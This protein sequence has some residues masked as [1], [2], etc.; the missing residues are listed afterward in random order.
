MKKFTKET[1]FNYLVGNDILDFNIDELENNPEFMAEVVCKDKNS[2]NLCSDEIKTNIVFIR[3]ILDNYKDDMDFAL[4]VYKEFESIIED[5]ENVNSEETQQD[6]FEINTIMF[7]ITR[8]AQDREVHIPFKIATDVFVGIEE[9]EFEILESQLKKKVPGLGF[10]YESRKYENSENIVDF[11]AENFIR[12]IFSYDVNLEELLHKHYKSYKEY[13]ENG[14]YTILIKYISYYDNDLAN[15]VSL[16]PKALENFEDELEDIKKNWQRYEDEQKRIEMAKKRYKD[17]RY[18]RIIER[19]KDYENYE[20]CTVDIDSALMYIAGV[21]GL[22]D[23]MKKAL[24][25]Y[26]GEGDQIEKAYRDTYPTSFEEE[27]VVDSIVEDMTREELAYEEYLYSFCP[28]ILSDYKLQDFDKKISIKDAK[29][30]N[31]LKKIFMEE[32]GIQD[33]TEKLK[34]KNTGNKVLEYKRKD[35]KSKKDK[36]EENE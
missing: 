19:A 12:K 18:S 13:E 16:N 5:D 3:R 17:E 26:Y 11:I 31:A 29:H 1:V 6:I 4:K 25:E 34:P 30:I 2:Y 9:F 7:N 23:Q 36:K 27:S 15:Y 22:E 14:K 10:Y 28:D 8:K 32:L 24:D 33:T 35:K 21:L 20:P